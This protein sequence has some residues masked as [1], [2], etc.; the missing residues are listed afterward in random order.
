RQTFVI[1]WI[2]ADLIVAVPGKARLGQRGLDLAQNASGANAGIGDQ[3][4]P[5]DA[6]RPRQLSRLPGNAITEMDRWRETEGA[7]HSSAVSQ[8]LPISGTVLALPV[9]VGLTIA[10]CSKVLVSNWGETSSAVC[11]PEL[12]T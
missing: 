11:S 10:N 4:R 9:A 3:E 8:G 1:A 7:G 6:Q 5:R 2:R 12:C